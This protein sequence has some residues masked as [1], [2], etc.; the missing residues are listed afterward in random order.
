MS[1]T[2][3]VIITLGLVVALG[4]IFL[5]GGYKSQQTAGQ[6]V[7]VKNGVQFINITAKGGYFP[8]TS[9]AKADIPT[10]LRFDTNGTFDCSASVRIPSMNI[11]KILSRTGSTDI[12]LGTPKLGTLQGTCGMGMYF[13]EVNFQS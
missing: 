4:V 6:N 2:V 9:I 7:E 10:I 5:G 11:A 12:D 3:L 8:R 1:K 13:F